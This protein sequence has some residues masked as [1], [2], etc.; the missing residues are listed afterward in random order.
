MVRRVMGG[1]MTLGDRLSASRP[2]LGQEIAYSYGF[3]VGRF[4]SKIELI[5]KPNTMICM[6]SK[7][8]KIV[9]DLMMRAFM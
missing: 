2:K 4:R 9:H 8:Q 3:T 5:K 6:Y 7:N 1:R